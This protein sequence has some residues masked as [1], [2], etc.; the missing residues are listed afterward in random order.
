MMKIT[1]NQLIENFQNFLISNDLVE[2]D[3]CHFSGDD[4]EHSDVELTLKLNES[5]EEIRNE[6]IFFEV[7]SHHSKDSQNTINK[8]FGQLLKETGKRKLDEE[9]ECLAILFPSESGKW[10]DSKGM[11]TTKIE[12][13]KYYRR[14]FSRINKEVF[15][16]FGTLVNVKYIFIFSSS[17][18]ILNVFEW[19]NFLNEDSCSILTLNN[20]QKS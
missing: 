6:K 3:K 9:K 12:G 19:E 10:T 7:K 13:E 8:V 11:E 1:E 16:N 5:W 20:A 17:A 18:Q 2:K 14:G 15:I 4:D